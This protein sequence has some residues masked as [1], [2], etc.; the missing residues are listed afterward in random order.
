MKDQ[1][2]KIN[3]RIVLTELVNLIIDLTECDSEIHFHYRYPPNYALCIL[4]TESV[5]WVYAQFITDSAL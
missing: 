1:I 3:I 2:L 5:H 4:N